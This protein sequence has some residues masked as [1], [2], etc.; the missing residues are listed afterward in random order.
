MSWFRCIYVWMLGICLLMFFFLMICLFCVKGASAFGTARETVSKVPGLKAVLE[1][2]ARSYDPEGNDIEIKEC[3]ICL[4]DFSDDNTK[5]LVE[6]DCS[7]K[8]VFHL[9]CLE[10]WVENNTICPLCR[11]EVKCGG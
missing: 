10:G 3:S 4:V 8:H 6:L 11:Q 7:N 9:E 5:K 1:Q 2:R